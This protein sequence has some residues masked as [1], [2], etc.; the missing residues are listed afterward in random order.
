M[1][2]LALIWVV[3]F[4]WVALFNGRVQ[5]NT[6][7]DESLLSLGANERVDDL[8]DLR[9][10]TYNIQDLWVVGRNR[11]KRMRALAEEL[12]EHD[13]DIV[14][15]QEAFISKDRQIL[16]EGLK[17]RSR[18]QHFQ[19]FRSATVGSGLLIASA[20]PIREASFHRYTVSGNWYKLWEGDWW[21]GKGVGL[22]RIEL[23]NQIGLVDFFN[24]HAQAGYGNS[25]YREVRRQQMEELAQ[26]I[27]VTNPAQ[28]PA[29]L[30]G[31]MNCEVE[32]EDCLTCI[33]GA[34]LIR[35]MDVP[36]RIDHIFARK[37]PYFEF[38]V[39]FSL[40]IRDRDG[41]RLSDHNGYLSHVWIMPI[42]SVEVEKE[43]QHEV[44]SQM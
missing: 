28:R 19:Y 15:F 43:V 17:E 7:L 1:A 34:D 2:L 21:A 14:G 22:A 42:Q 41:L 32:D 3:V 9:I 37:S 29:F 26:F 31:D 11:P 23:P 38:G 8:I 39:F 10:V 5:C 44:L 18:L 20:F 33:E 35:V 30:V 13:P 24:T 16:I 12:A 27:R 25:R 36:S 4:G 6:D 40:E